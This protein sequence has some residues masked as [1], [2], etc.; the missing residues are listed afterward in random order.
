MDQTQKLLQTIVENARMGTDACDQLLSKTDDMALRQELMNQRQQYEN[1]SRDAETRLMQLN[2]APQPKGPMARA[3]LWMGMQVNTIKDRSASHIADMLIQ[4][5]TMGIVEMTKA[6]N[7]LT[8]ADAEAQ[9]I[10]SA[11]I[12]AQQE[13]IDRLKNF[14]RQ[15]EPAGAAKA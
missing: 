11:L 5:A 8:D 15:K 2:V 12:T 7:S 6:R 4:G 14:L 13:A 3:G 10:A 1:A 9:G